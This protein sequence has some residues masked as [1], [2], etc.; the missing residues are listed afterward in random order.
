MQFRDK[1]ATKRPPSG[2][3]QALEFLVF[4]GIFVRI[5]KLWWIRTSKQQSNPL[6]SRPNEEMNA[7]F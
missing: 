6:S 2:K 3:K 5:S 1:N 4:K 7:F